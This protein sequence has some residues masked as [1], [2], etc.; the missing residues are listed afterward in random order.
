MVSQLRLQTGVVSFHS[1][2]RTQAIA[3]ADDPYLQVK[4][5]LEKV[6][7]KYNQ[8]ALNLASQVQ[9]MGAAAKAMAGQAKLEQERGSTMMAAQRMAQAR[10]YLAVAGLKRERAEKIRELV[11]KLNTF[12]PM[13]AQAAQVA[14]EHIMAK[15][16]PPR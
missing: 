2:A 12:T 13:Y 3:Q 16:P 9:S 8:E 11:E 4:G 1:E 10:N 7:F 6:I 14:V 5:Q 15:F